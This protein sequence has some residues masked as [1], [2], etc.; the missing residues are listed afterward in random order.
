MN[1]FIIQTSTKLIF[2][3]HFYLLLAFMLFTTLGLAQSPI[4]V[5]HAATGNA[6][7][8]TWTDA[9]TSLQPAIDNAVAGDE[10][11]VSS[12][13]YY[14]S[15]KINGASDRHKAFHMKDGVAI[16]GGFAGTETAV[17]ERTA[18]GEGEAHETILSGDL[19][20]ND[21]FDAANGGYQGT[22]G[23]DNCYHVV[24]MPDHRWTDYEFVGSSAILD[25]FTITGGNANG[26]EDKRGGG[27]AN[28]RSNPVFRDLVIKH[29]SAL[30]YGGGMHCYVIDSQIADVVFKE[31][32][33][34]NYDGAGLAAQYCDNMVVEDA[35]FIS[36]VA[37]RYGAGMYIFDYS[38][39]LKNVRF[40]SNTAD[41]AAAIYIHS[42]SLQLFNGL[43]YGNQAIGDMAGGGAI[44]FYGSGNAEINNATI[45]NNSAVSRGGGINISTD[46]SPVFNNCIVWGNTTDG[47]GSQINTYSSGT[48]NKSCIQD[49]PVSGYGSIT[50][51]NCIADDPQ[52]VNVAGNDYRLYG[53][54]PCLNS[55]NGAGNMTSADLRGVSRLQNG[56]I[57]MGAYEWTA[58]VDPHHTGPMT[59]YVDASAEGANI[60]NSWTD[61]FVSL[62]VAL[63]VALAGDE[64]WVAKG[65]Y[66]PSS[67][68]DLAV[69]GNRDYHF[70]M[71]DGVS[72]Y[73][74]F[75]GT[76]VSVSERTDFGPGGAN[77]TILSGDIGAEG[78]HTDNCFHVFFHPAGSLSPG[79][80]LD[81]FTIKDGRADGVA[82][83]N[84]G[85][86]FYG[87]SVNPFIN[88]CTFSNNE[89][90]EQGGG[91]FNADYASPVLT[92]CLFFENVAT[93]GGGLANV[94]GAP[95]LN[96]CTFSSNEATTNG[97]GIASDG[98]SMVTCNNSIV[99]N[100]MAG[101]GGQEIYNMAGATFTLN[102]SCYGNDA[103]D[104]LNN[105]TLEA[106]NNNISVDPMF[107]Y[108][109]GN[110]YRL[111]STSPAFDGGDASYN[112]KSAD[113]RGQ[114]RVQDNAIDMGVF[115]WTN[116]VDPAMAYQPPTDGG[117]IA[118]DQNV[119]PNFPLA[120]F[121]SVIAATGHSG[122]LVYKWQKSTV[123]ESEGFVDIDMSN[124][125]TYMPLP[126]SQTIWYR[127]LAGVEEMRDWSMAAA[128]NVVKITVD[129]IPPMAQ[130]KNITVELDANGTATISPA[131]VDNGSTDNCG[132]ASRSL[133]I[134]TFDCTD[135][136][137]PVTVTLTVTDVNNNSGTAT[138]TVTVEDNLVPT[139]VTQDITVQLDETGNASIIE[140]DVDNGSTDNC[141]IASRSLDISTFDC[142]D[143]GNP[144][145]V[146]LTATD[147]QNNTST[148][149][150]TVTVVDNIPPEAIAQNITVQLNEM[151]MASVTAGEI[152]NGSNDAC[153]I[154]L[155]ELSQTSFD[156]SDVGTNDVVLMV[157]DNQGNQST[158]NAVVAVEAYTAVAEVG[159][160]DVINISAGSVTANGE[161]L[162]LGAPDPV[163]HGFCWNTVGTPDVNDDSFN[164]KGTV[165]TTGTYSSVIDGLTPETT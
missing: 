65:V 127:R 89:A 75:A 92:N 16:F 41:G 157:E 95:T 38:P 17:D 131:D 164:Q 110:D 68:Y 159:M 35:D 6:D 69:D 126:T 97:G 56:T 42:S 125:E 25:G 140:A 163:Q 146:T 162:D 149:T 145:T 58:G 31:N 98:S 80:V 124:T 55:G 108:P 32:V 30:D 147:G 103:G 142:A 74:G 70:R 62:Q 36:N 130:T 160:L 24:N 105:G 161:I 141:G 148:N 135:V 63:D 40:I 150:S 158:A 52:F 71:V 93:N 10:I 85:G 99:W 37:G 73:G 22:T 67:A 26:P 48:F 138:A 155:L 3:R 137:N 61:A 77:E 120:P 121:S 153:G 50:K 79:S 15:V 88:N 165:S 60:G 28:H 118:A 59:L 2:M 53:L 18:F 151:G 109:A 7:G 72:I 27:V 66:K 23:D 144:V 84:Q 136:G 154:G 5:D 114:A 29:N 20:Q 100:N 76:E 96:N 113:I 9:F 57:D 115:E 1:T 54:S 13:T 21:D 78:D 34:G 107:V 111:M 117:M 122:T 156:V 81:G 116:G 104:V 33:T 91:M 134:S 152:D 39:T 101:A 8:T 4:Y 128:S 106:S 82:P 64:I 123:S 51:N 11:W 46:A 133:D 129:E 47:V 119:C 86:G 112:G 139:V 102:Y 45:V 90:S 143:V 94:M 49:D 83:H 14:P 44:G 43:F 87:Q 12:G 19:L 132:I